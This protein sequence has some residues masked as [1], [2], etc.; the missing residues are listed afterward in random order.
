LMDE[1]ARHLTD[2]AD[3]ACPRCAHMADSSQPARP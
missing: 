2:A 3:G 1:I